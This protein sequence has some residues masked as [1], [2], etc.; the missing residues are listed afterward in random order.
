MEANFARTWFKWKSIY[1]FLPIRIILVYILCKHLKSFLKYIH[2][3]K[4]ICHKDSSIRLYSKLWTSLDTSFFIQSMWFLVCCLLLIY[5][6]ICKTYCFTIKI[7]T[8]LRILVLSPPLPPFNAKQRKKYSNWKVRHWHKIF[9]PI[10]VKT[11]DH[12]ILVCPFFTTMIGD[13]GGHLW[14]PPKPGQVALSISAG[15]GLKS[16]LCLFQ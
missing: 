11:V 1:S 5:I 9:L 13:K 7:E 6:C 4:Y 12:C 14:P 2:R 8:F 15:L 16:W 10:T 3:I